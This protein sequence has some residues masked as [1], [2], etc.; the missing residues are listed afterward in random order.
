[1]DFLME[2]PLRDLLHFQEN[3]LPLPPEDMVDG[4]LAQVDRSNTAVVL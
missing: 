2:L 4:L 3:T 1:M